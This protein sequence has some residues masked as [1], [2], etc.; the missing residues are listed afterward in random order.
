LQPKINPIYVLILIF[1]PP[2]FSLTIQIDPPLDFF[3]TYPVYTLLTP[4]CY[5]A[6]VS[7]AFYDM[8]MALPDEYELKPV[9]QAAAWFPEIPR[10]LVTPKAEGLTHEL[11]PMETFDHD[12]PVDLPEF[13][14]DPEEMALDTVLSTGDYIR[15][16]M[17]MTHELPQVESFQHNRPDVVLAADEV[18]PGA[19]GMTHELP[20]LEVCLLI[21]IVEIF[22]LAFLLHQGFHAAPSNCTFR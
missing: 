3:D 21:F 22:L 4:L 12:Q 17:G 8:V 5:A 2:W 1:Y 7:K 15:E 13:L 16:A 20:D 6:P 19:V 14:L 9:N 18:V 10:C 11:P